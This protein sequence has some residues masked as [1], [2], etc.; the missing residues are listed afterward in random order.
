MRLFD[1][2]AAGGL[3]SFAANFMEY[4][5]AA[6]MEGPDPRVLI[7][8]GD[9]YRL[10]E[11]TKDVKRY[12]EL[13]AG[14]LPEHPIVWLQLGDIALEADDRGLAKKHYQKAKTLAKTKDPYWLDTVKQK[15]EAL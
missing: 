2:I 15:L 7:P 8:L 5:K 4:C 1:R 13:L 12:Y 11:R 14:I 6:G 10:L 9:S 3:E